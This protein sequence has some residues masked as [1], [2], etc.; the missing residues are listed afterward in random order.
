MRNR[1]PLCAVGLILALVPAAAVKAQA[2]PAIVPGHGINPSDFR[3]TTFA[4]GLHFP[5]S[6]QKL[7]DGSLLVG[8]SNPTGGSFF[9]SVGELVRLVDADGD[10]VADGPGT[11][12]YTGLPGEVSSMRVAGSLVLVTSAQTGSERISVLRL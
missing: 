8:T 7:S 1:F 12:L 2:P 9:N 11:V 5:L 4:T 3:V 6:M 10:G